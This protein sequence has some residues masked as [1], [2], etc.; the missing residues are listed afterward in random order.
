MKL[1]LITKG[2]IELQ[3][4]DREQIKNLMMYLRDLKENS[5]SQFQST[6]KKNYWELCQYA[7]HDITEL[8]KYFRDIW[9]EVVDINPIRK[10]V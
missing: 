5:W 8:R 9:L 10:Y 4:E 1:E 3:K 6:N 7:M 2:E